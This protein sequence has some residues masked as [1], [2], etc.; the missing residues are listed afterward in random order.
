[1]HLGLK[2]K[3]M[4]EA[5]GGI[6]CQEG[7]RV[8]PVMSL[9]CYWDKIP[10]YTHNLEMEMFVLAHD[11]IRGQLASK[12]K[13]KVEG[14]GG[15]SCPSYLSQKPRAG[16]RARAEASRTGHSFPRGWLL[17]TAHSVPSQCRMLFPPW[18]PLLSSTLTLHLL[19]KRK[20]K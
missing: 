5:S 16:K 1:M 12:Q 11:S 7:I 2:E 15:E 13:H 20:E 3:I 14:Q 10:G 19:I 18:G 9:S 8:T 4:L 6:S 17:P